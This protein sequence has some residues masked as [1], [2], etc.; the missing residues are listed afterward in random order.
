MSR[1]TL[2]DETARELQL[3]I[4]DAFVVRLTSAAEGSVQASEAGAQATAGGEIAHFRS[5]FPGSFQSD[6]LERLRSR[7]FL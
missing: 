1:A 2:K 3:A 6:F 7:N 5:I 4:L